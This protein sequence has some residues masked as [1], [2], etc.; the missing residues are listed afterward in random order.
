MIDYSNK[1]PAYIIP[2]SACIQILVL[3]TFWH[4]NIFGC[5]F[6]Q[7]WDIR[8]Y[9]DICL[10]NYCVSEYIRIWSEHGQETQGYLIM[11]LYNTLGR[12]ANSLLTH[13][14]SGIFRIWRTFHIWNQ[15]GNMLFDEFCYTRNLRPFGQ[16]L[17]LLQVSVTIDQVAM[18]CLVNFPDIYFNFLILFFGGR[19][20]VK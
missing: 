12:F 11:D 17:Q 18:N 13:L 1:W 15:I 9:S 14:Q 19:S 20:A 2:P 4:A 3:L 8:I 5:F 7:L 10:V 6:D 16:F